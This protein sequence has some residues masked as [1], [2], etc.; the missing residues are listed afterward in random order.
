VTAAARRPRRHGATSD[1]VPHY[2]G[3]HLPDFVRINVASGDV[4]K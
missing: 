1:G 4:Y 3:D 2:D